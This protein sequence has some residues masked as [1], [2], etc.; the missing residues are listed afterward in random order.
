MEADIPLAYGIITA[1]TVEQAVDRAGAKSGNRGFDAAMT[2]LEM[3][4]LYRRID[5]D[6]KGT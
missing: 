1:D 3:A 5:G 2:A 4:R 6:R